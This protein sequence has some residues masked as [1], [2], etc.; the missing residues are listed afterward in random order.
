MEALDPSVINQRA[1]TARMQRLSARLERALG[2]PSAPGADGEAGEAEPVP[3][4]DTLCE[5]FS[6]TAFESE[7]LLLAAACEFSAEIAARCARL[8]GGRRGASF[9]LCMTVLDGAHWDAITPARPLR[10]WHL[11]E[12][13]D[14]G[15]VSQSRLRVPERVLH[16]LAGVDYPEPKL[17][18]MR[19]LP[20]GPLV[21][22]ASQQAVVSELV[23]RLRRA[24]GANPAI[25][26]AGDDR[27]ARLPVAIQVAQQLDLDLLSLDSVQV[28]AWGSDIDSLCRLIERECA[29]MPALPALCCPPGEVSYP[30]ARAIDG[31]A[32]PVF[33]L[34]DDTAPPARR[35]LHRR[36][37]D[38]PD[39]DEQGVLWRDALGPIAAHLN[40]ALQVVA[41]Q[42]RFSA[43]EIARTSA[44]I[45]ERVEKGEPAPAAVAAACRGAARTRLG[46]LAERVEPR[47]TWSDLV[48]PDSQRDVLKQVVAQVRARPQVYGEWGF[49]RRL[50]R[51]LGISALFAGESGTGKTLAAE[52]L[53]TELGLD[54]YRI[55]L[56]GVVSKYIGETEKNL[57]RVFA[58]AEDSGAVLLFDEADALFGKRSEVKDSHD[59]Y[60]NI[61]VS[62]LLQRMETYRGLAIL[63]T[64]QRAALDQAFERRLRFIV[65][66]PFPDA[67]QR[68]AIWRQVFPAQ[69]PLA[70]VDFPKLAQLHV[71]GGVIRNI[72]LNAAF[73]AADGGRAVSMRH[74]AQ[75]ARGE[76]GK[77]ER[78]SGEAQIRSWA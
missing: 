48:L 57:S 38:K 58:A 76:I 3:A 75:A 33:V 11:L 32:T 16:F 27:D 52:V 5:A 14:P 26:L 12:L 50:A 45:A 24:A 70:D 68:E 20:A 39:G 66:F 71:T 61:E 1:L 46:E 21:L 35:T 30:V 72:A 43:L 69:V 67:R 34:A 13:E 9:G 55:D 8:A 47:A 15:T 37:V 7:A 74:L 51:G 18:A 44:Q 73:M 19:S 54:L 41:G 42:Y 78:P 31:L 17:A 49:G 77:T 40:G 29:L 56:S 10:R 2:E 59:R 64:N 22:A 53:A 36:N 4:L 28:E 23:E 62:Y 65:N 6:L 60:A 25:H 63:T